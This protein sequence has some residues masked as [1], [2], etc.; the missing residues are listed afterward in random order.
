MNKILIIQ[1]A[2]I[3]D[4]ILAT[5]VIEKLHQ[6]FPEACIDF[7]L[8]KGNEGLLEG[9]PFL[10]KALIWDKKQGKY[11]QLKSLIAALRKEKYDV[12]INLQRFMTTGII[13][14]FSGAKQT[15][16]FSKNP[17]SLFFSKRYPHVIGNKNNT[18]HE[19]DRNLSLLKDLTNSTDFVK[20]KLYPSSADFDKVKCLEKYLTISPTSVWFTKQYPPE[21][22]VKVI[23]LLPPDYKVFLLGGKTDATSCEWIKSQSVHPNIEVKAGQLSFLESAAL[24]KNAEMNY[25]NDSAPLHLAS[26]TDAPVTA[27]FCS[28]IPAFGFGPLSSN[29]RVIETSEQLDCRPCG[30]HGYKACPKGH[31]KCAEIEAEKIIG[32]LH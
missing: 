15:I 11:A 13:T 5:S 12:A 23:N 31:F 22:W 32:S 29:S 27:V 1:T 20:P 16:G 26:A 17:I 19:V 25:V 14:A 8:R 28:T 18:T 21:K 7:L 9:H 4:V 6:A 30:L 24:M 2:F 10:N 3:G